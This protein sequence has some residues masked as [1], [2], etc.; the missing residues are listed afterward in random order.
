MRIA[1]QIRISLFA[2]F[3]LLFRPCFGHSK[4][5]SHFGFKNMTKKKEFSF[6]YF[7]GR[8]REIKREEERVL[9]GIFR[10]LIRLNLNYSLTFDQ[11][12]EICAYFKAWRLLLMSKFSHQLLINKQT[13]RLPGCACI[14]VCVCLAA[15]R[16]LAATQSRWS[17]HITSPSSPS[18][19]HPINLTQRFLPA[20]SVA[21]LSVCF[22]AFARPG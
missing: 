12:S 10:L 3:V 22:G 8:Q 13:L 20:N 19:S 2:A 7:K 21:N 6:A 11:K 15:V 1:I 16:L 14:S 5:N 4:D 17:D 9:V 18:L